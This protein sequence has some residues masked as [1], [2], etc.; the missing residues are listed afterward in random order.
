MDRL[1]RIAAEHWTAVYG[2][3]GV[4]KPALIVLVAL[5]AR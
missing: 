1:V 3:L 2:D 4:A 5:A